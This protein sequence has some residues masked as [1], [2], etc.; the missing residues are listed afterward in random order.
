MSVLEGVECIWE[1]W[2]RRHDK[3]YQKLKKKK[4]KRKLW[5]MNLLNI[6]VLICLKLGVT[7]TSY[8]PIETLIIIFSIAGGNL[9]NHFTHSRD[10]TN[11]PFQL[12]DITMMVAQNSSQFTYQECLIT[13]LPT[14]VQHQILNIGS[15]V[16]RPLCFFLAFL[17]LV[18]NTLVIIVVARNRSL[19]HPSMIMICSLAVTDVIFSDH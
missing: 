7:I 5:K 19:Q 14:E 6:F 13:E 1:P 16:F 17:S 18:F 2:E 4:E 10:V 12:Q 11:D 8:N 3:R 9:R 15:Y